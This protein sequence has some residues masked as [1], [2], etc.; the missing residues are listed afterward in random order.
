MLSQPFTD[1]EAIFYRDSTV[2]S[3][4]ANWMTHFIYNKFNHLLTF[5]ESH[6][7]LTRDCLER[8]SHIISAAGCAY[9]N[10]VG[11]IDGTARPICRPKHGQRLTYSGYKKQHV[12][13][14]QSTVLPNGIIGRLDGPINGRRHD[15]ALNWIIT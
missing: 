12:L 6:K 8:F 10:V 9:P 4:I 14:Y 11:F 1:L 3:R 5:L 15:F 13:K 7:W 2:I